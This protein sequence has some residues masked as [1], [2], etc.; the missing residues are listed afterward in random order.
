MSNVLN[1][2]KYSPE[3]SRVPTNLLPN[4]IRWEA[5]RAQLFHIFDRVDEADHCTKMVRFYQQRA[6]DETVE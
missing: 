1:G 2:G 3:G 5:A 6:M 4:A